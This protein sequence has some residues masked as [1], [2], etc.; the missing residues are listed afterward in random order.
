[1]SV[2]YKINGKR[3]SKQQWDRRKGQG[4]QLNE[5]RAPM[6]TVAYSESKPLP[7][8]ALSCH[9]DLAAQ[10]N[11]VAKQQGLTGIKWDHNGDCV[12]TSRSDRKKWLR[13]QHQH[14]AD[15][16]YGD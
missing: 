2:V 13:S 1:V 4:L 9:R 8:L 10:Y 3:V 15:G 14:D 11:A 12:I 5:Q 16:G 6:G 7:S